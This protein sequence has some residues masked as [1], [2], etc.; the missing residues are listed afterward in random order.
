[1]W[2]VFIDLDWHL[3]K[4]NWCKEAG[5][6]LNDLDATLDQCQVKDGDYLLLMEGRVPPKVWMVPRW[7]FT[8]VKLYMY[9]CVS[10]WKLKWHKDDALRH[11]THDEF[12]VLSQDFFEKLQ[13]REAKTWNIIRE[14]S[15]QRAKGTSEVPQNAQFILS[16]LGSKV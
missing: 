11:C 6:M 16:G 10:H 13:K 15:C 12:C 7:S 8:K 5:E 2:N 1:M 14:F 4:T 9:V 3:R